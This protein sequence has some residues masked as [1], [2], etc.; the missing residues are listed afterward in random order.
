MI[1]R[2]LYTSFLLALFGTS[3]SASAILSFLFGFHN[4][5]DTVIG[6]G[7]L[8]LLLL[9]LS[10]LCLLLIIVLQLDCDC[11]EQSAPDAETPAEDQPP[12]A[13]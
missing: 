3:F 2:F 12:A 5:L 11:T 10:G 7:L 4:S 1:V 6:Q 9:L 13:S 8:G